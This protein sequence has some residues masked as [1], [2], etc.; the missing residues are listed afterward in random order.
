MS[1][2]GQMAR[3]KAPEVPQKELTANLDKGIE[4]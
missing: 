1:W 4:R 2:P 3:E